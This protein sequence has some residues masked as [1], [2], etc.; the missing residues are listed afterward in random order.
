MAESI[1]ETPSI[2]EL[3]RRL[4]AVEQENRALRQRIGA[5]EGRK[6]APSAKPQAAKYIGA[7]VPE[8]RAATSSLREAFASAGLVY[9]WSG[10]YGGLHAGAGLSQ[11]DWSNL[12]LMCFQGTCLNPSA[13]AVGGSGLGAGPLGGVQAG[14]NWQI[15]RW[16]IG[17]DSNYSFADLKTDTQSNRQDFLLASPQVFTSTGME[18]LSTRIVGLG[19]LG[20]RLGYAPE[21]LDGL[22]LFGKAGGAYARTDVSES[23]NLQYIRCFRGTSCSNAIGYTGVAASTVDSWGWFAGLGG[24]YALTH[25]WSASV[26]YDYLDFGTKSV[27]LQGSQCETVNGFCGDWSRTADL[28]QKVHLVK[29]GL[30][31]HLH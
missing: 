16:V 15:Q 28:S 8:R 4:A 14:Y 12:G 17:I 24:E 26:E 10:F 5:V 30:N 22:L 20:A 7:D 31:Y 19:T 1:A 3:A 11:N 13:P 27:T 6:A 21:W 9:S 18:S 29:F 25:H 2:A 23:N